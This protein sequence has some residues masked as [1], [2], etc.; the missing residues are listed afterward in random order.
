MKNSHKRKHLDKSYSQLSSIHK[1]QRGLNLQHEEEIHTISLQKTQKH[2]NKERKSVF[3]VL[4]VL[5]YNIVRLRQGT[6]ALQD[7]IT[8]M[9][10]IIQRKE[11]FNLDSEKKRRHKRHPWEAGEDSSLLICSYWDSNYYISS[12]EF[13]N[14]Q[15]SLLSKEI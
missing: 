1:T 14:N 11:S 7:Q 3:S 6:L 12:K 8:G 9:E 5:K 15:L 13:I 10:P 4:S 2:K